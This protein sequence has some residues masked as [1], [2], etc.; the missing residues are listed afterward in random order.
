[1][2]FSL[3]KGIHPMFRILISLTIF[4]LLFLSQAACAPGKPQ[5]VALTVKDGGRTVML[6]QGDIL[7]VTLEGN[8]TTGYSWEPESLDTSILQQKGD[9]EF[10]ADNTTPGFV[11]SPGKFTLRFLAVGAGQTALKLIYHR[12][13]E[14]SVPPEET[15]EVTVIVK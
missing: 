10:E 7:E 3:Q 9:W 11:G 14:S 12:A 15:F 4:S 8:P 1:M 13:F 5:T 6:N 2:N